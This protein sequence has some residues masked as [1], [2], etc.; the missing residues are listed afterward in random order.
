MTGA[1]FRQAFERR[2]CLVPADGFYEWSAR[3]GGKQPWWIH[4]R[5]GGVLA[6]ADGRIHADP[7]DFKQDVLTRKA[8]HLANRRAPGAQPFFLWLTY[9]APHVGG[10]DQNPNPPFNCARAA[11]PAP[12]HAHAFDSAPL[13]KTLEILGTPAAWAMSLTLTW[14]YPCLRNSSAAASASSSAISTSSWRALRL[15]I[16]WN[17]FTIRTEPDVCRNPNTLSA[18]LAV[19][20]DDAATMTSRLHPSPSEAGLYA[21]V[22][23][24]FAPNAALFTGSWLLLKHPTSGKEVWVAVHTKK[25]AGRLGNRPCAAGHHGP[26]RRRP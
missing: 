6:F 4:H 3:P 21:L 25:D 16:L 22:N 11:K 10:P 9:T 20:F 1:M 7:A 12:R 26:R 24:G 14:W 17:A 2:R 18:P 8:V 23:A 19:S 15:L 13:K 5:R